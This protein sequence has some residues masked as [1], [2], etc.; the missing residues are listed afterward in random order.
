MK[1]SGFAA[2]VLVALGSN[3]TSHLGD[4]VRTVARAVAALDGGGLKL[5]AKSRLYRTPFVPAGTEPDVINAAALL[6]TALAPG[7]VLARLHV[8]EAEFG[9][10]RRTRWGNRTLDLDLLMMDDLILPDRA[11]FAGWQE[12]S[13]EVQRVRAP[14]ELV[15]PHPRMQD[16]AFVLVPAA[17]IAPDWRHPVDG[18][19]L[20]ELR[21]ALAEEDRAPVR[22]VTDPDAPV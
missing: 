6:E 3:V 11:T 7:A 21:D 10:E 1:S 12:L 18:R 2:K 16:R 9:R 15:L 8:I 5:L 13:P 20:A 4:P 14:D 19:T 17:E 22:V